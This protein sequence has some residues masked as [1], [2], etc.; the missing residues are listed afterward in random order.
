MDMGVDGRVVA[1]THLHG[2]ACPPPVDMEASMH[3][4]TGSGGEFRCPAALTSCLVST[5][6]TLVPWSAARWAGQNTQ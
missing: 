3:L 2:P 5:L 6:T 4:H 1:L